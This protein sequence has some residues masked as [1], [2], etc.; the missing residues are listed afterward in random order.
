VG[1]KK[2]KFTSYSFR[3]WEVPDQALS[4]SSDGLLLVVSSEGGRGQQDPLVVLGG[5]ITSQKAAPPNTIN[6]KFRISTF[7]SM[8]LAKDTTCRP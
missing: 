8:N 6:A 7:R 2:Q 4:M 1:L 5:V 3:H